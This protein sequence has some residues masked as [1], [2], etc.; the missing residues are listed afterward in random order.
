MFLF[1]M[2]AKVLK[3]LDKL[4]K[5][6]LWNG[7]KEQGDTGVRNLTYKIA[8]CSKNGCGYAEDRIALGKN[9]IQQKYGQNG[10]SCPDESTDTYGAGLWRTIR[11][12]W[13]NLWKDITFQVGNGRNVLFW[14]DNWNGQGTLQETF[15]TLFHISTNQNSTIKDTWTTQ[16]W[17][18]IFRRFLNDWEV[19]EWLLYFVE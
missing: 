11:S 17:N 3:V 1:P 2:P 10:Q 19:R 12:L 18:L 13:T 4:R 9:V 15:P 7:N 14:K 5:N 8:A 16:G 6:F